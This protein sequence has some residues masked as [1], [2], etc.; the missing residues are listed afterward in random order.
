MW[1]SDRSSDVCSSDLDP[2]NLFKTYSNLKRCLRFLR[3]L[4][5]FGQIFKE[6]ELSLYAVLF[7]S[8]NADE[9]TACLASILGDLYDGR[10]SRRGELAKTLLAYLD[11]GHN[12]RSA[13]K[14]LGVHINTVHQRL[15]AIDALLGDWRASTRVLELPMALR[16]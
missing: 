15:D 10:D 6:C 5:R 13:A 1:I 14:C 12:A 11:G 9:I 3:A 8:Q 7:K 16:L 2:S 4:G